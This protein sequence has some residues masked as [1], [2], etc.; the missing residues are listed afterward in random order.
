MSTRRLL[1]VI[2]EFAT[3]ILNPYDL[4][5]LLQR[6]SEHAADLTDAQGAGIMLAGHGEGLLGFAAATDDRAVQVEV[7]QDHVEAGPCHDAFVANELGIV[8]ELE[9]AGRWPEY[10]RRALQLGLR[11]VLAVPMNAWGQTIGVI[12]IYREQPGPWSTDDIEAAQIVTAMGAGYVL[13]ADQIRAQH[14]LADQL[15]AALESRDVIGQ[16]KGILMSRD[17]LDAA[18]A[19]EH[20]RRVSQASNVKLRDVAREL[21]DAEEAD[22]GTSASARR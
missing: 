4:E 16:A 11:S 19:F 9:G 1:A 22:A 8:E 20:L 5:E 3:T 2:H 14:E 17:G 18:T 15:Q 21:V 13:H 10:E 12:N 6:L 7:I